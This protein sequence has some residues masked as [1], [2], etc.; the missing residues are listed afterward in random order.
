MMMEF[1]ED[2]MS[3]MDWLVLY[4]ERVYTFSRLFCLYV[5]CFFHKLGE[6]CEKCLAVASV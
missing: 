4:C 2:L 3:L 6:K 1:Q 5:F